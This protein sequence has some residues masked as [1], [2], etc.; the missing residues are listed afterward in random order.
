MFRSV[1][2]VYHRLRYLLPGKSV[3]MAETVGGGVS[4][5]FFPKGFQ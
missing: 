2:T 5:S 1:F 3:K 4:Q